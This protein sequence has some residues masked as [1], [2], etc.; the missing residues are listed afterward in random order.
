M[1]QDVFTATIKVVSTN[2]SCDPS[3]LTA[4]TYLDEL[5]V[6]SLQLTEIIM[7]LEDTFDIRIDQNTAEAW[8]SL[9]TVGDI[10]KAVEKLAGAQC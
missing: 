10:V 8:A 1:S 5:G 4:D 2:L 9:K 6:N 7:D 3:K